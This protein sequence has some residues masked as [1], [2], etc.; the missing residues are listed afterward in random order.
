MC[1]M[2]RDSVISLSQRL[3]RM[4]KWWQH[5]R[6][7]AAKCRSSS[8]WNSIWHINQP[9]SRTSNVPSVSNLFGKIQFAI[10][11]DCLFT[12]LWNE[13]NN[14]KMKSFFLE[15][16]RSHWLHSTDNLTNVEALKIHNTSTWVFRNFA[17]EWTFPF[18]RLSSVLTTNDSICHC[19][20][21][22]N[23]TKHCVKLRYLMHNVD[24]PNRNTKQCTNRFS[25]Q[26]SL[27]RASI[28]LTTL[29][30][31]VNVLDDV[32]LRN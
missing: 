11:L 6:E 25:R 14:F 15:R 26:C 13:R 24:I 31:N 16:L 29:L 30:L 4:N 12:L 27:H 8:N 17:A 10:H 2:C 23:S 18:M 3:F 21:W 7:N 20:R 19:L 9:K 5:P 1:V 22:Q 28:L 32:W